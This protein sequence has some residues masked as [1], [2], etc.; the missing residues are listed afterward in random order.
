MTVVAGLIVARAN[1]LAQP[2]RKVVQIGYLSSGSAETTAH[3]SQAFV[4][5]M[6]ALGYVE[7]ENLVISYRFAGGKR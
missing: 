1:V 2:Q 6:H 7:G 3:L 4:Q 5:G